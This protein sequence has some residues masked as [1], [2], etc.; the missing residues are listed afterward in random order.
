MKTKIYL[1]E[2]YWLFIPF[3][4]AFFLYF[5]MNYGAGVSTDSIVFLNAAEN[6]LEYGEILV[7]AF[8]E[9]IPMTH[10]PPLYSMFLAITSFI[11][12]CGVEFSAK[13]MATL[14]FGVN[15]FLIGVMCRKLQ[16]KSLQILPVLLLFAM[17]EYMILIH[18]KVFTEPL[19]I[20]FMLVGFIFL[21][22]YLEKASIKYLFYA[23]FSIALACLTRYVGIV[24]VGVGGLSILLFL[25]RKFL[26]RIKYALI[27]GV[28]SL[29]PLFLWF[30]RNMILT[31]N[32]TNRHI[33]FH[34]IGV[35]HTRQFIRSILFIFLPDSIIEYIK[36]TPM[37]IGIKIRLLLICLGISILFIVLIRK[38]WKSDFAKLKLF[39]NEQRALLGILTIF[40]FAYPIFLIISISFMDYTTPLSYRI[41]LPWIIIFGILF[42]RIA[43]LVM[44]DNKIAKRIILIVFISLACSYG[45]RGVR[46][47]NKIY[48]YGSG[49]S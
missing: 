40:F 39:W 37:T 20:T 31:T 22:N 41:M 29:S 36:V 2:N 14:C 34:P 25:H 3:V 27:F 1:K 9:K 15:F 33:I 48:L 10:F 8:G 38:F 7:T 35:A 19:F 26:S 4:S 6:I 13:I 28:I 21:A 17:S 24:L 49:Y 23:G 18:V 44:S 16:L 32:P 42:F 12:N 47:T 11:L 43:I 5:T 46:L 45:I 30:I